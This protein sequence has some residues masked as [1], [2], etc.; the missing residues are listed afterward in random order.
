[1][2]GGYI[3]DE[4]MI[5]QKISRK[6]KKLSKTE[7]ELARKA[8]ELASRTNSA[9]IAENLFNEINLILDERSEKE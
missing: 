7:E 1:M 2:K 9:S 4:K 8:L 6:L 3:M 5:N